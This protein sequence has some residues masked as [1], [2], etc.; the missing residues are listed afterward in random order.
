[1][2]YDRGDGFL[3]ILNQ[4]EFHLVQNRKEKPSPRS[5]PIQFVRKWN[6]SFLSVRCWGFVAHVAI[7]SL[8]PVVPVWLTF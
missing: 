2:G 8:S 6:T 1:M 7:L 3:L 4:M 5:Y